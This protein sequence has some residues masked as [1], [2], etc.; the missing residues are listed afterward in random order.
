MATDSMPTSTPR[1]NIMGASAGAEKFRCGARRGLGEGR[2]LV[3]RHLHDQ[4]LTKAVLD[5]AVPDR[6]CYILAS[7][8]H[9]ACL[10]SLGCKAIGLERGTPD[11]FNG[12]FVVDGQGEPDRHAA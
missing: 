7:D 3:H 12:H 2:G 4:N 1:A 5:A 9:N 8:G 6:P 10:N 11:P